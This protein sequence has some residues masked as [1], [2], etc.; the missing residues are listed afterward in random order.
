MDEEN[1]SDSISES[2]YDSGDDASDESEINDQ[3]QLSNLNDDEFL[4]EIDQQAAEW[5]EQGA[6]DVAIRNWKRQQF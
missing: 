4:E 2:S 3:P 5:F 6:S 1:E